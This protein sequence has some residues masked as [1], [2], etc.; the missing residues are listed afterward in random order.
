MAIA[1]DRLSVPEGQHGAIWF[2]S[3]DTAG[4]ARRT[5]THRELELNLVVGGSACYVVEGARYAMGPRTLIWLF[6]DQ[7]HVLGER[8]ADFSMWVVVFRPDLVQLT[9]RGDAQVL[10]VKDPGDVLVRLLSAAGVTR[11]HN[12]FEELTTPHVDPSYVNAGLAYALRTAWQEYLHA[13]AQ[14]DANPLHPAVAR[15]A[16]F[17]DTGGP[18]ESLTELAGK[19][20]LSYSRLSRLF[21]AQLGESVP[22]FRDRKRVE[23]FCSLYGSGQ[24]RTMLDCALA[25]GFGSYAQ[26]YRVFRRLTGHSPA[27]HRRQVAARTTPSP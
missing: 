20:G 24:K 9:C 13:G 10:G 15:M 4:Q 25:A 7:A 2:N 14:P 16:L 6:P 8:S 17:L 11:L 5:H 21:K 1:T 18:D 27:E 3:G 19:A 23:V 22:A 26:F 12:L